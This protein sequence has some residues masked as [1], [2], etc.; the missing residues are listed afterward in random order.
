MA[1]RISK[2]LF[3]FGILMVTFGYGFVAADR[4]IWPYDLIE[5]AGTA[6]GEL[7]TYWENDF[8]WVPTRHLVRARHPG[9]GVTEVTPEAVPGLTF[10][11]G[12]FGDGI[13]GRL[14]DLEGRVVN[15]WPIHY[16]EIWPERNF[17]DWNVFL[18]GS[19]VLPDGSI[20]FNF[21]SG[22]GFARMD[23]CGEIVWTRS[24]FLH[25]AIFAAE[26][27]TFWSPLEEDRIAQLS[28]DGEMLRT[29]SVPE[30]VENS[31][32]A[33]AF[34]ISDPNEVDNHPNDVE[35]LSSALAPAFPM[36]EAGDLLYSLRDINA[37]LV[38]DPDDLK[39][40]WMR[41]GPWL[42][43]H[44]PDFLPDGRISVFDNQWGRKASRIV[45]I[46]PATDEV[47]VLYAGTAEARFYTKIRGKHQHLA[48]GHILITEPAAGRV[49]EVTAAG[50]I[51]WQYINRY[52][53]DRAALISNAIR[54]PRAY[55][56]VEDWSC[57]G[58]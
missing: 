36:F 31:G 17:D 51:V 33:G 37:V 35:V 29:L 19:L 28:A 42:R 58:A 23:R 18:H 11:T 46:D 44:D 9:S 53:E 26:D 4:E 39:I 12:L 14:V 7:R 21:D 10:M 41:H 25:H 3:V 56:E 38:I 43:Q 32:L 40:K 48:S 47:E 1:D 27:G 52:D 8:A 20:L 22:V 55:F 16:S 49:F 5:D 45:A 34:F 6:F 30:A 2:G 57:P 50:E 13:A 54:Y 15:T 24:E